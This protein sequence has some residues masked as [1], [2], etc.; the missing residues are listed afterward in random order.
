MICIGFFVVFGN[1]DVC[2]LTIPGYF[3]GNRMCALKYKHAMGLGENGIR[4][5]IKMLRV[6]RKGP[7]FQSH[8]WCAPMVGGMITAPLLAMLA[9]YWFLRRQQFRHTKED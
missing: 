4:Q 3:T 5:G 1:S 2:W 7:Y 8:R 6:A 9:V